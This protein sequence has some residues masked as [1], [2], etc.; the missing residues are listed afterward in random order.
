MGNNYICIL[1]TVYEKP[2]IEAY[3]ADRAL[4]QHLIKNA[5]VKAGLCSLQF[6]GKFS[7]R[8]EM[9]LWARQKREELKTMSDCVLFP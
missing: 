8:T 1:I 6:N 4:Q 9:Q 3:N 5:F 2:K 7:L